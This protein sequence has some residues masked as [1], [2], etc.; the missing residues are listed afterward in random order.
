MPSSMNYRRINVL[1][2]G[3]SV[4]TLDTAVEAVNKALASGSQC[5]ITVTGVHGISECQRDPELLRIHN[6]S[7]LSTPDGMPLTW[8][9]RFHGIGPTEMDRVYG[10]DLML[11]IIEDGQQSKQREK[12]LRHFLLGGAEGVA[13][14]LRDKLLARIPNAEIV[15]IR[16]PPF[17]PLTQVEEHDLVEEL[18][19]LRPDCL[20]VGLSTPKQERFMADLLSRYGAASTGPLKLPAPLVMFGV[21]A[22]FDFHAGLMP[23]A[24]RWIQ[25]AGMEWG[26]RLAT[27]PRRL[28]RRYLTNNP[29]FVAR[30][31]MQLLGLRKYELPADLPLE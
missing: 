16:T 26:Y 12:G 13:E 7:L 17:R 3:I 8:L 1:G 11:R 10:P 4:L 29:L 23:Q 19:L 24:P 21:G 9:G 28:W 14:I 27:E 15:G 6:E 30:I 2:V 5:Y 25:R 18:R 31:A 20:W 22:A